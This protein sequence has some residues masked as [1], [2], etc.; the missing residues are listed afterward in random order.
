MLTLACGG[1]SS[2]GSANGEKAAS[3]V[4]AKQKKD[5]EASAALAVRKAKREAAQKAKADAEAKITTEL[6]RLCV[7]PEKYTKDPVKGCDAAG[8]AFDGFMRRLSDPDALKKWESGGSDKGIAMA[9]VQ[10]NQAD[11]AKVAA[12]QKNALDG[13]GADLKDHGKK[14]MQ[15]CIDKFAKKARPG[16]GP[17]VPK[18]RPG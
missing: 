9:V 17:A 4:T 2:Q 5:A 11:S 15:M 6:V 12:C 1:G 8:K 14:L 10:C 18:R 13:A 7:V 3:E 16:S